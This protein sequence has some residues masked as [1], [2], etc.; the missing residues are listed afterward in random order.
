M[1]TI[2]ALR[3]MYPDAK[4]AS[5]EQI[6]S[7]VSERA[8]TPLADTASMLGYST[9]KSDFGKEMSAGWANYKAG[10]QHIG[11]A[12][13]SETAA[14]WAAQ[15]ELKAKTLQ[16]MSNAPHSYEEVKFGD[17]DKGVMNYLGSLAAGSAPFIAEQVA[18]TAGD[19]L[20]GGAL[21]P[22]HAARLGEKA[23]ELGMFGK[24][25]ARNVAAGTAESEAKQA[26]AGAVGRTIAGAEVS[27]PSSTG[28]LLGAQHEQKGE[29]NLPAAL[30]GAVPYSLLNEV[31]IEGAVAR[32]GLNVAN[33]E[34]RA[35][36]ALGTGAITGTQ[37]AVGEVGQA[38]IE[39]AAKK[40]VDNSYDLLGED[41]MR[42]LRESAVGGFALGHVAGTAGGALTKQPPV[43]Q[44]STE[45][46]NSVKPDDSAI[47]KAI[48]GNATEGP[49][50]SP[51]VDSVRQRT[52]EMQQEQAAQDAQLADAQRQ[53][54]SEAVAQQEAAAQQKFIDTATTYGVKPQADAVGQFNIAGK[55]LFSTNQVSQFLQGID[56]LNADKPIEQKELIGA[57]IASGNL[58][59]AQT[60]NPKA[61][62]N[63]AIKFLDSWG[64]GDAQN[65]IEA[66]DRANTLINS[67]EGPKALKEAEQLNGFVKAITGADAPAFVSLQQA[68][69]PLTKGAT[70][71]RLQLQQQG[72]AGLRAVSEQGGTTQAGGT[73]LGNVRPPSIQPVQPGSIGAGSPSIQAGTIPSSGVP[74][75]AGANVPRAAV[76][77]SSA[78]E[79]QV[80]SERQEALTLVNQVIVKA[81]GTRN[82][83]IILAVLTQEKTQAEI[84]KEFGI[85]DARVNQIAGPQAQET[86]GPRILL[87]ARNM[88]IS[89]DE[90]GNLLETMA[91]EETTAEEQVVSEDILAGK[92]G[93]EETT[94]PQAEE[95]MTLGSEELSTEQGASGYRVFNPEVSGA[96]EL[97]DAAA[98]NRTRQ[99]LKK[100][101]LKNL[102]D[103]ELNNLAA[104][105]ATT[106]EELDAIVAELLHRQEVRVAKGEPSAVQKPSAA[107]KAVRNKPAVSERVREQNAEERQA[108]R[109]GQTDEEAAS[110]AWDE[111]VKDFPDA[112]KFADLSEE[113]QQDWI[114]FG[115]E[116]WTKDDVQTELVKLA[117]LEAAGVVIN[118]NAVKQGKNIATAEQ[119]EFIA[120]LDFSETLPDVDA[121]GNTVNL[122][123]AVT[124]LDAL[125]GKFPGIAK[126][127]EAV[128][129]V[130]GHLLD[131]I[132]SVG[133]VDSYDF[134]A[135]IATEIK[136]DGRVVNWLMI[137]KA[138]LETSIPGSQTFTI[139]HE[140]GHLADMAGNGGAYSNH[141][142]L[143]VRKKGNDFIMQGTIAKELFAFY[144]K[145]KD[146]DAATL[147]AYPFEDMATMDAKEFQQEMF[148]QLWAS[149]YN[150]VLSEQLKAG[151]PNA[152]KFIEEAY[153]HAEE[154]RSV[155]PS[156][157]NAART[158]AAIIETTFK[159]RYK[160]SGVQ[161]TSGVFKQPAQQVVVRKVKALSQVREASAAQVAKLPKPIRGPLQ[162]IF[163]NVVDFAK[164]GVPWAAFT[165]D[166]ADIASKYIPS[167]KK[168]VG[169]MKE[170]QATRTRIERNV[171][172]ILQQYDKLPSE[173]KGTGEKSV[174][175]FLMD[176]TMKGLWAYNPGWI[177]NFDE[178]KDIDADMK[179][180]FD[181]MPQEA[182]NLI[183]AVFAHGQQ[184]LLAMQKSVIEN[185]NT[186][187]DAL[188][189]AAKK[190]GDTA[191]EADLLKKK[192]ASLTDYRTLMRMGSKTPY[193]PLKRFGNYVVVGRSQ[194]YLDAEN[195]RDNESSTPDEVSE[196]NKKLREFEKNEDHYFVQF[197]ETMGEA[198]A[199]AREEQQNY[200]LVEPFEKDTARAALYGGK[201]V[202]GLF[203]RLRNMVE[204][205]SDASTADKSE[206][207]INK[208]LSDL[209][210]S[211]LSDQSARQAER[212]RRKIAGAEKDMMRAFAT[213]GRANAHFIASLENSADIY[214]NLRQMKAE[215]DART[216]GR[217]ERRRYYNEFMKRH[218]MGLEYSPSPFVDKALSTTSAWMLLTNPS[219]YL[220]NM[221]QP[222]MMSL[223]VVGGKHGYTKTWGAFTK[224]YSDIS[225]VIRKHGL[226]EESYSKLPEDVRAVVEQLVNR[227]R[228]DISL[229]QDLGRWRSTEDSKFAKFGQAS[230]FL[231][232]MAQNIETINRVATAVAAYRL[233]VKESNPTRAMN[234]ADKIIYTTHGDYSGFNAPRITRSTLGRLATQFRKFQLIQLSLIARLFHDAF[235][236]ADKETRMIGRKALM[237][238]LG[239]TAVMGGA[240]GL[241][242]FY[243]VAAIY[244]MLFGDEDE[245]DNPELALRR[246][247]GN[248]ALADLL[249]KG[250]PAMLGVDLSGKLG[251]GQMLS[252]LPYTDITLS[253]KG[254][255]EV[256]G[257]LLTGPFG[258]LLAKSADGV[259]YIGQGDYYKGIEQLLPTGL[260]NVLKGT[261]VAT[262]GVTSRTGDVT[263]SPEDISFVDGFMVALGLP[264]KTMTDRQFLQ[265]AK[266][267]FDQFYN[268]KASEVKRAYVR[269]YKEGDNSG[270]SD[271]R[272]EWNK[273]Q[274]SRVR[275]GY[276]KQPLSTLIKAPMEQR[277][278]ERETVGGV[279]V[280]KANRGFVKKTS[281]L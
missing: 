80:T 235:A 124:T 136:A 108:A 164:K 233:E 82:A 210:L 44:N 77:V 140:T 156:T 89:K 110:Q 220:Q 21:T 96:T 45:A 179:E 153:N 143:S 29:Y 92:E 27:Y 259:S 101:E 117:K 38:F 264:T 273:L 105:E 53:A 51:Q 240:M 249:V 229:E 114:S 199:I 205:S 237:F 11:A 271:A 1:P 253:R 107:K 170:R 19:F 68:A 223:P 33:F 161:S 257:T 52:A 87:A 127:L 206:R 129:S 168:Y 3:E 98:K 241:P 175:Q 224:A 43:G 17:K 149:Y 185:I 15:N 25:I 280:N 112:P 66:A 145:S 246:A 216:P 255:Y 4:D 211:L 32:R 274:E 254:V 260:S 174:N 61:V 251:M 75:S 131:A 123:V 247:I 148:A 57:A 86:W 256:A 36:R 34:N 100:T 208:L 128:S 93:A 130:H 147:L 39:N 169:L 67:L 262:E 267:E 194:A 191:E 31:G 166:L 227:G 121:D 141:P 64:F 228:I 222:F 225:T 154:K 171:D 16:A 40:S 268:D 118:K 234:Y 276:T 209:H 203:H 219:Y 28:Q 204:E 270:L 88:G 172:Q 238:T 159:N 79:A 167:A 188:I 60:A 59:V 83:D 42:N 183:K 78:Q 144:E 106:V 99:K 58:K 160:G 207:A 201:D 24:S 178:T 132:T 182:Q 221:T 243:G 14:D 10:M 250:A 239:H 232:S 279:A 103:Y 122:G 35:L 111:G 196:A 231:R 202:Q 197:A 177:K 115:P 70:N 213:Q 190:A 23:V 46:L 91:A 104:D 113:Q 181:A 155:V 269:A 72:N 189:E 281:E 217:E 119:N 248:D 133:I 192:A 142:D 47:N 252:V 275:N 180:R 214:D 277:K 176:S 163:D 56:Q 242:G 54:R 65:K 162:H 139:L 218:A 195:T 102:E 12:L 151:A 109:E 20:S 173:V 138:T 73:E 266:Y 30:A 126:A 193:A 137:T 272:E 116:N 236:G 258:G 150:T 146:L 95:T 265:A 85:S 49:A 90:M 63:A 125:Q 81:F 187:Y 200:A 152:Y 22:V 158:K 230:E 263:M 62:N 97:E 198:K 184:S 26:A 120:S 7:W 135:A 37:E 71:E 13:G 6:L 50:I 94:V 244:G 215:T 76:P 261:R 165:E 69:Q 5:D 278:R 8:G 157:T 2:Q 186:E 74:T 245:P 226:D 18:F 9:P 84:A 134:G 55:R 48:D 212:K 41:A